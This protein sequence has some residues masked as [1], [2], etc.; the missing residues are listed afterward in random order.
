MTTL[1]IIIA[2]L[3]GWNIFNFII[4]NHLCGVVKFHGNRIQLNS[5]NMN[6]CYDNVKDCS[7]NIDRLLKKN[8]MEKE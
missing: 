2:I 5:D 8:K 3:T 7:D 1:Y 6:T 4:I